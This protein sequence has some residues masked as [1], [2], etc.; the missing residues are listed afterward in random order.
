MKKSIL[1]T[2]GIV[3]GL[4]IIVVIVGIIRFDFMNGGNS[5]LGEKRFTEAITPKS[6]LTET[7]ARLIAE[8]ACIKGGE[9]LSTGVYNENTKT[10]WFDAN[11]NSVHEG[12]NPACVVSEE[13]QTAEINW[14][15]TGLIIPIESEKIKIKVFFNNNKLDPEISCNK[16]FPVEREI[17]KTSAIARAALTELLAGETRAENEA[18]F[19]TSLNPD[20]KIQALTI[21]NGVA[22]VDF[23]EQLQAQV[24]GSCKVTAIRAQ[25]SETLKQFS[26]VKDVIISINGRSEDILQP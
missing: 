15:C 25:I 3:L 13:T 19:T 21:E 22:K 5:F 9:A 1:V 24:G 16:V 11:L 10:W 6:L 14:R 20:V 2:L 8:P 4:F 17:I 23:N 7:E 18:G 26:S 12:C